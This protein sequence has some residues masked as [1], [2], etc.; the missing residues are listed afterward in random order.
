MFTELKTL[1]NTISRTFIQDMVGATS[2]IVMLV[3]ALHLPSLL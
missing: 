1:N 2:L 3:S